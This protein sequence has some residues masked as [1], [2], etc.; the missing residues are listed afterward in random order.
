MDQNDNSPVFQNDP[1]SAEVTEG[2]DVGFDTGI[3]V[4]ATDRDKDTFGTVS[5]I[6]TK[7]ESECVKPICSV[8]MSTYTVTY[9]NIH[10]KCPRHQGEARQLEVTLTHDLTCAWYD[11]N[12]ITSNMHSARPCMYIWYIRIIKNI[13]TFD[14]RKLSFTLTSQLVLF[15]NSIVCPLSSCLLTSFT[16]SLPPLTTTECRQH[17]LDWSYQWSADSQQHC[18]QGSKPHLWTYCGGMLH[19]RLYVG[20]V[21]SYIWGLFCVIVGL[22]RVRV[23]ITGTH[24]MLDWLSHWNL[25]CFW[26]MYCIGVCYIWFKVYTKTMCCLDWVTLWNTIL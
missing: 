17:F 24:Y 23:V 12:V 20:A 3:V 6:L 2:V 13:R 21:C 18:G 7:N 19:S 25:F 1:Y 22:L 5:Y 4:M 14:T 9:F 10:F 16:S 15:L 8:I 26:N 11:L